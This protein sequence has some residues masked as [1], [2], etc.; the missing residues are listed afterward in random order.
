MTT[1]IGSLLTFLLEMSFSSF[2]H[3]EPLLSEAVATMLVLIYNFS[4]HHIFTYRHIK[5]A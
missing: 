5:H 3:M 4:F 2:A 1:A